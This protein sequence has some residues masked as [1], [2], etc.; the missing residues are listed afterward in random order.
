MKREVGRKKCG[1]EIW[2]KN[3]QGKYGGKGEEEERLRK[4]KNTSK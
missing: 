2:R 1:E 4:T 3:V